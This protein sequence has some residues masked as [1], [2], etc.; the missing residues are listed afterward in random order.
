MKPD[1]LS[2][3]AHENLDSF[4]GARCVQSLLK[5]D[6]MVAYGLVPTWARMDAVN[7]AMIFARWLAAA[8]RAGDPAIMASRSMITAT[9]GLG[10][11]DESVIAESFRVQQRLGTLFRGIAEMG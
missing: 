2:F 11:L 8:D 10:L 1:I 7:P 6:V 9:C 5:T 4:F 3:D